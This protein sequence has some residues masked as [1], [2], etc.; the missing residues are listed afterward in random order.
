MTYQDVGP[1]AQASLREL[2]QAREQAIRSI[3]SARSAQFDTNSL[4]FGESPLADVHSA[5]FLYFD[6]ARPYRVGAPSLWEEEHIGTFQVPQQ[7]ET[8]SPGRTRAVQ[9]NTLVDDVPPVV[10]LTGLQSLGEWRNRIL[11]YRNGN[12]GTIEA[13]RVWLSLN[14][15]QA[16]VDTISEA[17]VESNLAAEIPEAST[18]GDPT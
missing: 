10:E 4:Q 7:Y 5:V 18:R 15:L 16:T 9:T 2:A 6:T 12:D 8:G 1:G 14:I 13:R 11:H 3:A 17:L